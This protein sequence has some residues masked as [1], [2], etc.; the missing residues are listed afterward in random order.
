MTT[1]NAETRRVPGSGNLARVIALPIS[2]LILLSAIYGVVENGWS[3][4]MTELED[5][6]SDVYPRGASSSRASAERQVAFITDS[7]RPPSVA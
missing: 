1:Q 3:T 7:L 2:C 5:E 4:R 6:E